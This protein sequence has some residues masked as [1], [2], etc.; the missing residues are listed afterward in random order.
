MPARLRH[1]L[2]R[3]ALSLASVVA[4]IVVWRISRQVGDGGRADADGSAD[5][6]IL[7]LAAV[8][9]ERG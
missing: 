7:G 1:A 6:L 9:S 5:A 8:A 2:D 3:A 4:G